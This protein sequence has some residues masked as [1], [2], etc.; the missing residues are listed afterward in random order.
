[1]FV[2]LLGV[3][4]AIG[5]SGV[6]VCADS[7]K[8]INLDNGAEFEL[9]LKTI[10]NI[11]YVSVRS[12]LEAFGWKVYWNS[13]DKQV[14]GIKDENK[15]VIT[16]GKTKSL[17]NGTEISLD[18]PPIIIDGVT[19]I[20]NKFVA[21]Y[22]GENI[23]W[24][25]KDNLIVTGNDITMGD[26][27]INGEGNIVIV[28]S[29][30]ILNVSEGYNSDTLNDLINEAD[31]ILIRG[32]AQDAL[33]KYNTILENISAYDK[34]GL[35]AHIMTNM[36]NAYFVL[37][38]TRDIKSNLF[39][40]ISKYEKALEI[41]KEDKE[42]PNYFQVSNNLA[43]AYFVLGEISGDHDLINKSISEYTKVI[44]YFEAE[45]FF[46]DCAKARYNM[47]RAYFITGD[48]MLAEENFV[49]AEELCNKALSNCTID[50]NPDLYAPVQSNLGNIYKLR[51]EVSGQ[52]EFLEKAIKGYEEALKVWRA[53]T[54]PSIYASI[55]KCIG[56]IYLMLYKYDSQERKENLKKSQKAYE[57]ALKIKITEKYPLENAE[58]KCS[59]GDTYLYLYSTENACEYLG[60]AL[61]CYNQ[62]LIIY[63]Q[64]Q[65]AYSGQVSEK[66][67]LVSNMLQ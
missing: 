12:V 26:V 8:S 51:A 6:G 20:E 46:L 5:A 53:E 47:G 21:K 42:T 23:I 22:F 65:I 34:P 55:H 61:D 59:M 64:E 1:L 29:S 54:N 13:A 43:N 36:G 50:S 39:Y 31:A 67:K 32:Y 14:S 52:K 62:A 41:Y 38:N 57:E 56:D 16:V 19:Y 7:F 45:K 15:I 28:G 48:K 17:I 4:V 60:Y 18:N 10:D 25:K 27:I 63:V 24:N 66:I 33:L 44:D 30:M 9:Q 35:Y 37:A 58:I 49:N 3:M 11:V 2:F 40:A